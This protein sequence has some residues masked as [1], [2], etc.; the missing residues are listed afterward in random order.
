[1][2]NHRRTA[3]AT[4]VETEP[5][6]DVSPINH[7]TIVGRRRRARTEARIIASAI[8]VFAE[9]GEQNAVI[10]DFIAAAGI[11][12]GTFYNY[13]RST[14]E[15]LAA[16]KEWLSDDMH[17]TITES[18]RDI[19]DPLVR[20]AMGIRLWMRKATTDRAWCG[21]VAQVRMMDTRAAVLPI[22]DLKQS[23]KAGLLNVPSLEVAV[24][25]MAGMATSA[26]HRMLED[27][28]LKNYEDHVT[29]V[30]LQGLGASAARIADIMKRPLPPF[31]RPPRTVE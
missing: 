19:E 10:D 14:N 20:F 9:K 23:R 16:A 24:D 3:T 28:G 11:A 7:R 1:M 2:K 18:I 12:R 27:P 31:R 25:L 15:L 26:M 6:G 13:F 21:F 5:A 29:I 17:Q 30:I 8:H 22:R 4:V